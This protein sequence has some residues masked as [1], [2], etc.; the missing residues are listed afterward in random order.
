MK[1]Y[2]KSPV[3]SSKRAELWLFK[4]DTSEVEVEAEVKTKARYS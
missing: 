3:C 1:L 4:I 2:A